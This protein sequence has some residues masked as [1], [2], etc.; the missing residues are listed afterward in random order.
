[1]RPSQAEGEQAEQERAEVAEED[2]P[3]AADLLEEIRRGYL[4][5]ERSE[6]GTALMEGLETRDELL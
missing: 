5:D 6:L 1:M 2:E 4:R 3:P